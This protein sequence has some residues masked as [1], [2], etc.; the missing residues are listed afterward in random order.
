MFRGNSL[1]SSCRHQIT[2]WI[3][4]TNFIG[5]WM[6]GKVDQ[7]PII[8]FRSQLREFQILDWSL[9]KPIQPLLLL[10]FLSVG[11]VGLNQRVGFCWILPIEGFWICIFFINR[12][13]S[14]FK[15][16]FIGCIIAACHSAN[17]IS[18]EPIIFFKNILCKNTGLPLMTT[19]ILILN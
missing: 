15:F 3:L 7:L 16:I 4:I 17:V 10:L 8:H 1:G 9:P 14:K 6:I 12:C 18:N 13:H 11:I 5:F 2:P 19:H